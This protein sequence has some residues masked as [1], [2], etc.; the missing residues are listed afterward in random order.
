MRLLIIRHGQSEADILELH[1]GRADFSLTDL[2]VREAKE[3][4]AYVKE[5]YK[6]DR[7]YASPL[8]RT[9]STAKE[10]EVEVGIS[11]QYD[12]RLMEFNNGMESLKDFR[13][14]AEDVLREIIEENEEDA[15][16]AI[17]T[18][19]GVINQFYG[20]MFDMPIKKET[21]F[22]SSDTGIHI[23]D[24]TPERILV[25]RSN[26][27]EHLSRELREE[28]YGERKTKVAYFAGGCF[29]C[30][31]P[32]FKMYGASKVLCGYS[33]G[34]EVNPTYEEVKAQK[35]THRES[36][37]IEYDADTV[38]YEELLEIYLANVDPFDKDGQFIDK[39]HSY[40]LAI[41]YTN[42]EEKAIAENR[43]SKLQKESQKEVYISIEELKNFYEAED[44]HQDYYLKNPDEFE[45]ELKESGRK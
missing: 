21:I 29:W 1:E 10:L 28:I 42:E 34:E 35:T 20:A 6:I 3:M 19:G 12:D 24:V 2:G 41:Y 4:A 26:Q 33:G 11:V 39:G 5:N 30:M 43:I 32:V 18:H 9:A 27:I 38:S 14:R 45:K 7:I 40:T 8:R 15:T 36:M 31:T 16:V 37:A 17:V 44:Y 22:G 13:K 23:W 25:V